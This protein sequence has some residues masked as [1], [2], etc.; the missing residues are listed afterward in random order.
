MKHKKLNILIGLVIIC[1]A[2]VTGYVASY[3][4]TD[5]KVIDE[6]NQDSSVTVKDGVVSVE[7]KSSETGLIFY[8]GAKV[9][10]TAY[11][12]LMQKIK[13]SGVSCYIVKM[14]LNLALLGENRA[15][16]VM[17]AHPEIKKWYIGGHSLG[18]AFASKYASK[19]QKSISGLILLGAYIFGD[20]PSEKSITIYGSNDKVLHQSKITYKDNVYVVEGGNHALFGNY[21]KQR[22]DGKATITANEQQFQTAALISEFMKSH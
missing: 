10:Y 17:E 16:K 20:Y 9:Q 21:G 5:T 1:L 15:D 6:M 8:P 13:K 12:P 3:Y 14:P 11:T 22:G 2:L 7:D 4:P 19:H 18:G